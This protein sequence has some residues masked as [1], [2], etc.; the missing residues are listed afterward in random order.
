MGR[1]KRIEDEQ[2][3]QHAREVF[4]KGGAF[5]STK[6]IARFAG[7]S[8]ATLFQR[9]PTKAALFL[10]AMVPPVV[11]VGGVVQAPTKRTDPR[12]ALT[13][14]GTRML[15]YFRTLIPAV[16]HL[17]THPSIRMA[18]VTAHFQKMPEDA[19]AEALA[20][21]LRDVEAR[22]KIKV[23]DPMAAASL[24]VSAIHSLALFEMMEMHGGQD[25]E[26]A[27]ELYVRALWNGLDPKRQT[28]KT[29]TPH[30]K[31]TGKS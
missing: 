31:G 6:E 15:A 4:L 26:H 16:M 13:E 14:I 30:R 22:G 3:L 2:L 20:T 8:E 10:A 17:M 29:I 24:L 5:G 7:I 9:F 28:G 11:D 21:Y 27:V 18:D 25:L 19:L 1:R 23:Q 12:G